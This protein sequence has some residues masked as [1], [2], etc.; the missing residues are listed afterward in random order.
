MGHLFRFFQKKQ[1]NA[2]ESVQ[3]MTLTLIGMR[4][5]QVYK[6]DCA[7]GNAQIA[8]LR[9]VYEKNADHLEPEKCTDRPEQSLM[10]LM[11]SCGVLYWNGFHGPHPK[12]LHDGT[13]FQFS[14]AVNQ[15]QTIH[16]DGSENFPKGYREFVRTLNEWLTE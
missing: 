9:K 11:N 2:I 15:G 8:L 6:I 1:T 5:T 16:A 10:A 14:A 4:V 13:M 12:N 7:D 3:E